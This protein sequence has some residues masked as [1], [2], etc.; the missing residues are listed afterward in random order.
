M[1]DYK[2]LEDTLKSGGTTCYLLVVMV[3]QAHTHMKYM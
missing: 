2:G 3:S 1:I